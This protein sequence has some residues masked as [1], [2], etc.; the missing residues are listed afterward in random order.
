MLGCCWINIV[1]ISQKIVKGTYYSVLKLLIIEKHHVLIVHSQFLPQIWEMPAVFIH[2]RYDNHRLEIPI[3]DSCTWPCHFDRQL[4]ELQQAECVEAKSLGHSPMCFRKLC[5]TSLVGDL[6]ATASFMLESLIASRI[7]WVSGK[8][9]AMLT[10]LVVYISHL[11]HNKAGQTW[12]RFYQCWHG[13]S[14]VQASPERPNR[15]IQVYHDQ[16]CNSDSYQ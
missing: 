10:S 8:S 11:E 15:V 9:W 16:L 3:K 4:S 13:T 12:V 1:V 5:A 7:P 6:D 2:I 14:A